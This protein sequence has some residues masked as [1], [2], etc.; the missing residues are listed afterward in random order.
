MK[1]LSNSPLFYVPF[2]LKI[3]GALAFGLLPYSIAFWVYGSCTIIN[4]V[5]E[6]KYFQRKLFLP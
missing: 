4:T 6:I 5:T 2:F 1:S 3:E